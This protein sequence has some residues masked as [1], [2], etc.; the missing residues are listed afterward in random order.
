MPR[1][2]PRGKI[3]RASF[4]KKSHSRRGYVRRD[5]SRVKRS[6]VKSTKV[7]YTCAKDTGAQ[8]RT[9]SY[10]KVLPS[11]GKEISLTKY[12]YGTHNSELSR[13]RALAN[14]AKSH[15][16]LKVLRRMNLLRNYQ[17]DAAAKATMADDVRYL[18]RFHRENKPTLRRSRTSRKSRTSLRKSRRGSRRSRK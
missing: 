16:S 9:P 2:C 17:P 4:T 6:H 14:A 11:L 12:G 7:G 5:G 1:S 15:G 10:K 18:S 13:H 3:R 8:G